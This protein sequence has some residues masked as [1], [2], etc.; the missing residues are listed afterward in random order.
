ME[1]QETL[2]KKVII[3]SL[4]LFILLQL[5]L[6]YGYSFFASFHNEFIQAN[7][8]FFF[9]FPMLLLFLL[10]YGKMLFHSIQ[11]MKAKEFKYLAIWLVATIGA[12]LVTAIAIS[13][14][15]I[16]NTND[17]QEVA[18][19]YFLSFLTAVI[20]APVIEEIMYRFF[21]FR[22]FEKVNVV[23][24]HLVTAGIFAFAHV[25]DYVLVAKDYTQLISML[26]YVVISLGASTLYG[27]TKNI[28]YPILL[29]V[30]I[31]C[32]SLS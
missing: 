23:L 2:D 26:V 16:T 20:C 8:N 28:C 7:V 18:S 21:L 6:I 13:K 14:I 10:L 17:T 3:K 11:Q 19:N 29:H 27:K 32:I 31:N 22:S 1:Y 25:W 24:A 15:G 30:L 4:L 12:M 9:Y 5:A